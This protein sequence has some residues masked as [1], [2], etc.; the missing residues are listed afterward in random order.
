M[1]KL[2]QSQSIGE[3]I[4]INN[5]LKPI[6]F[7]SPKVVIHTPK[8]NL[9]VNPSWNLG[10][11][12]AKFDFICLCNDDIDFDISIFSFIY[13]N[14][15][16]KNIGIVGIDSSCYDLDKLNKSIKLKS[17]FVRNYGFGT[18]MFFKKNKYYKIPDNLKIWC[19]DDFLFHS[20]QKKNYVIIGLKIV[21]K[22]SFT[23]DKKEFNSIKEMDFENY[24][25]K[26]SSPYLRKFRLEYKLLNIL[27][28]R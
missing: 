8:E 25:Y 27:G 18:L 11:S 10:V 1:N 28:L 12:I 19:G 21:T 2:I 26:Y 4:I 7:D 5:S 24:Q 20:Q 23:S 13:K 6:K 15:Y 3:I 17:S 9:Y 16:K 22:M 14:I